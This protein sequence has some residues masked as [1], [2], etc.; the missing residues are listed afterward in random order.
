MTMLTTLDQVAA[1]LAVPAATT[2]ALT[3]TGPLIPTYELAW[4]A[5]NELVRVTAP[6]EL[7]L[8]SMTPQSLAHLV[9]AANR[10]ARTSS[11]NST[12]TRS[13]SRSLPTRW[14]PS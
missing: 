6:L 11:T 4:D 5:A 1:H 10:T 7:D 13:R 3:R 8:S 2:L 9:A 12:A 14:P